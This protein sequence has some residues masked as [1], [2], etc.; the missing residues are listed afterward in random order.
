MKRFVTY[1]LAALLM[2]SLFPLSEVLAK[3]ICVA[4]EFGSKYIFKG[5]KPLKKPGQ[6]APLNGIWIAPYRPADSGPLHGT[7]YVMG[8]GS[9]DIGFFVNLNDAGGVSFT[10]QLRGSTFETA[11]GAYKNEG[12]PTAPYSFVGSVDCKGITLPSD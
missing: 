4:D 2:I 9:I 8:D 12:E 5:V 6:V 7:A 1:T 11:S 3:D 10:A